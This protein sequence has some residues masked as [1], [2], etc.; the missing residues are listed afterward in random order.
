MYIPKFFA[1]DDETLAREVA[2][3]HAFGILMIPFKNGED[4]SER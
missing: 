1:S 2:A 4:V 3:G